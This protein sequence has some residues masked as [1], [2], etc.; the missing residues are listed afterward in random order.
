MCIFIQL[1]VRVW[2][3]VCAHVCLE[4]SLLTPH[5]VYGDRVSQLNPKLTHAASLT[6]QLALSLPSEEWKHKQVTTPT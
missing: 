5:C 6:S 2:E 3:G 1:C 4:S